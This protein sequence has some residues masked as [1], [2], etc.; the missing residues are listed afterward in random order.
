AAAV[1]GPERQQD[2]LTGVWQWQE[3]VTPVGSI[4]VEDP[5]R[6][7]LEFLPD[8]AFNI[9]ADCNSG[10]GSYTLADNAITLAVGPMTLAAC[11]EG[12]LGD[13]FVR[14]VNS[15]AYIFMEDGYLYID[16]MMDSG[17]MRFG[18]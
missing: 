14:D 7:V 18:R 13:R 3:S 4:A 9:T 10:S 5:S 6:Y 17:T 15:A 2:S 16:L 12:S 11:P 1:F 8:G